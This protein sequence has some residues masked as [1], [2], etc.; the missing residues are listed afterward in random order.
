MF[1]ILLKIFSSL[2]HILGKVVMSDRDGMDIRGFRQEHDML[3]FMFWKDSLW[4]LSE[5]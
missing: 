4:L 3:R 5:E 1:H 2:S